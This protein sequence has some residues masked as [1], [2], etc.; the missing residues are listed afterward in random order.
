MKGNYLPKVVNC[1]HNFELSWI[2]RAKYNNENTSI[3][4][5]CDYSWKYGW[6]SNNNDNNN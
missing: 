5:L 2:S 1:F 6:K 3:T 4:T